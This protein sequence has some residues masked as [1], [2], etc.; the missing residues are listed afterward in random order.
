MAASKIA[1]ANPESPRAESGG[2]SGQSAIERPIEIRHS[3]E[4]MRRRRRDVGTRI[5]I[6]RRREKLLQTLH[7]VPVV[8][9]EETL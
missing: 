3:N 7:Q 6:L 4:P 9:G 5:G 8:G 1:M 2:L